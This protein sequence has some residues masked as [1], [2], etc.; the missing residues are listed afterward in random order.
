MKKGF[1]SYIAILSPKYRLGMLLFAP[2][3]L[4]LLNA[5]LEQFFGLQTAVFLFG[6]Y[7]LLDLLLDYWVFGGICSKKGARIDYV[8]SSC[9]GYRFLKN[10]IVLDIVRRF[11]GMTFVTVGTMG[12]YAIAKNQRMTMADWTFIGIMIFWPYA[13]NTIVLNL[14]RYV[15]SLQTYMLVTSFFSAF[16]LGALSSFAEDV[17]AGQV[18]VEKWKEIVL[19]LAIIAL[20]VTVITIW[21]MLFRVRKSYTDGK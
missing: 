4:I 16:S 1:Q 6:I 20:V 13:V 8:K 5:Y 21:H 11:L 17:S 10:G 2:I 3:A 7:I 15:E 14:G 9:Y 12:Y 18:N 19:V